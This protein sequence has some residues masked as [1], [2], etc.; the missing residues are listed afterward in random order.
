MLI[1]NII[2]AQ[3]AK[4]YGQ[5]HKKSNVTKFNVMLMKVQ[6]KRNNIVSFNTFSL[7]TYCKSGQV[8]SIYVAQHHKLQ[9]ASR[10]F[11]FSVTYDSFS[12]DGFTV[13]G[14]ISASFECS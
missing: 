13:F 4:S 14:F 6:Y 5:W 8:R 11:T 1:H 10:G 2:Q 12:F 7:N 9:F 3:H